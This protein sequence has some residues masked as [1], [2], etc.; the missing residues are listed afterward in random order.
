MTYNFRLDLANL[1]DISIPTEILTAKITKKIKQEI[2]HGIDKI[3][4]LVVQQKFR[5]ISQMVNL[6]RRKFRFKEEKQ[7]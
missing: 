1:K 4:E 5:K 2:D 7:V 3:G 6:L